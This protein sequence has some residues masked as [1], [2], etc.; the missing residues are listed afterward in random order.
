[1]YL[2]AEFEIA[3]AT[4]VRGVTDAFPLATLIA[5]AP[6]GL[7]ANHI[8]IVWRED[9]VLV[10]HI[11][12]ANDL[13]R[14]LEDGQEVL[15]VFQAENAYI[16]PNWYPSKAETHRAVP[17][18][19]YQVVH[20]NGRIHFQHDEKSKRAAIGQLTKKMESEV[21]GAEAWRM[22]DAPTDYM[23]ELLANIVAFEIKVTAVKAKSK[24][25]QNRAREDVEAVAAALERREDAPLAHKMRDSR[26]YS[27]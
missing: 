19:N 25:S 18:W 3:D 15:A 16:S 4:A 14:V 22:S 10:G 7:A 26:L 11:A 9:G 13:H 23:A 8:P 1:M 6:N 12:R 27:R 2:P 21:N 24:L 20:I 5:N 17:T